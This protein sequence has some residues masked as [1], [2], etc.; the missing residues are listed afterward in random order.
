MIEDTLKRLINF[1]QKCVN[2]MLE[3]VI[4][5]TRMVF[6]TK[7]LLSFLAFVLI[8]FLV[9]LPLINSFR[10]NYRLTFSKIEN[11]SNDE[12]PKMINPRFQ[13]VDSDDQTYGI[14][15][16]SAIKKKD[17]TLVL[18]NINADM[19]LR[20]GS[21]VALM[22]NSGTFKYKEKELELIGDVSLFTHD[23]YEFYTDFIHVDA[24]KGSAYGHSPIKGQGTMGT[25]EANE[26]FAEEKGDRIVLMGHV[27]VVLYPDR[28][29]K[30]SVYP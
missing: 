11:P 22:S 4:G 8:C 5:Y 14:S 16:D 17:N 10:E 3:P 30:K 23:G 26:F 15:A 28:V 25:I 6:A 18:N 9:F 20:N 7:Y 12:D 24:A 13:G 21:W 1:L 19:N 29:G 27:K 2:M